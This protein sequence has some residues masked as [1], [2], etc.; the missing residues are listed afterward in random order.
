MSNRHIA[1]FLGLT[2]ETVSRIRAKK[3]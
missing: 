1:S 3:R 2:P